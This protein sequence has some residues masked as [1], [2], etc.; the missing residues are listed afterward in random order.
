MGQMIQKWNIDDIINPLN[1]VVESKAMN[2]KY[3]KAIMRICR[4]A[5]VKAHSSHS[6]KNY[7]VNWRVLLV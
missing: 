7:K 3:A 1:V 5:A 6:Y 2:D 4:K